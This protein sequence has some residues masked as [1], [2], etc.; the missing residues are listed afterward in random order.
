MAVV[1]VV[2]KGFRLGVDILLTTFGIEKDEVVSEVATKGV[3]KHLMGAALG[4]I[5]VKV[6][7]VTAQL[8]FP[9][10][11]V[12]NAVGDGL[13]CQQLFQRIQLM[14]GIDGELLKPGGTGSDA[15]G[16]IGCIIHFV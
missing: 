2:P 16:I 13:F 4:D 14:I 9:V 6:D 5:L 10:D 11:G 15:G 7:A 12:G 1:A 3:A 8:A